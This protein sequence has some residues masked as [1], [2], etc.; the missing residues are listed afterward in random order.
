MVNKRHRDR[1][2][3]VRSVNAGPLPQDRRSVPNLRMVGE[4]LFPR[5]YQE[6]IFVEARERNIIAALD[7]GSGKT[8]IAV[9]LIRAVSAVCSDP[10]RRKV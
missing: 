9:M 5:A 2:V 8:L 7:T 4:H 10:E 3:T 6:E 1:H